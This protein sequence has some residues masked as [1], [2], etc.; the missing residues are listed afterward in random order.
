MTAIKRQ[1]W[2]QV[3]DADKDIDGAKEEESAKPIEL[4]ISGDANNPD[5]GDGTLGRFVAVKGNIFAPL[6]QQGSKILET[7]WAKDPTH[8][9]ERSYEY[10]LERTCADRWAQPNTFVLGSNPKESSIG[11]L[12]VGNGGQGRD[13]LD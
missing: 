9:G 12:L 4:I 8:I 6:E 13:R 2:H 10:F 7:R 11:A 1:H 3:K 5:Q